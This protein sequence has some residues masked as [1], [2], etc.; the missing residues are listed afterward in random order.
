MEKFVDIFG[1]EGIYK[2]GNKGSLWLERLQRCSTVKRFKDKPSRVMLQ[3][4]GYRERTYLHLI[5]AKHWL[6]NPGMRAFVKVKNGDFRDMRVENLEWVPNVRA[7]SDPSVRTVAKPE[8][9]RQG[10]LIRD[11]VLHIRRM[12]DKEGYSQKTIAEMYNVTPATIWNIV[13]RVT[14]KNA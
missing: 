13:N 4:R 1:Y 11:D 10:V 2:I 7:I 8:Y 5:V 9:R 3:K 12:Y 14:W 6:P